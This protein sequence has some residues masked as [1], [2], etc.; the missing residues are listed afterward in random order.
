MESTDD[1]MAA[2]NQFDPKKQNIFVALSS[3]GYSRK[4]ADTSLL[5]HFL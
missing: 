3:T 2:V 1:I 5:G 4:A